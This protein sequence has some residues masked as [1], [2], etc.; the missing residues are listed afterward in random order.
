MTKSLLWK[1][2]YYRI[3]NP[4]TNKTLIVALEHGAT[5]GPVHGIED[6]GETIKKIMEGLP[7]AFLITRGIASAYSDL[8][9]GKNSPSIVLRCDRI[10][11]EPDAIRAIS[12]VADAEDLGA[13]AIMVFMVAGFDNANVTFDNIELIAKLASKCRQ[14]GMPLIVET[15][16]W[17]S[18]IPEEEKLDVRHLRPI[19]RQAAE[20]GAD[21]LKIPYPGDVA[22]FKEIL[23]T[24]PVPC[25]VLGGPETGSEEEFLQIVK[26]AIDSG[27][28]GATVGRN[29]WSRDNPTGMVRALMK[30]IHENASVEEAL[31]EIR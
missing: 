20:L 18:R 11:I 14:A 28:A 21:L 12:S 25:T 30:I 23:R 17:R 5:L 8:F 9:L 1:K 3:V 2:R 29:I 31:K 15:T 19:A 7:D 16:A 24:C 27:A 22:S 6:L 13:D 4:K 26:D 10:S